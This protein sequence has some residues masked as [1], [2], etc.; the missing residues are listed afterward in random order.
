MKLIVIEI[1]QENLE[2]LPKEDYVVLGEHSAAHSKEA[3]VLY[4]LR[5][6]AIKDASAAYRKSMEEVAMIDIK[7]E[8]LNE[9]EF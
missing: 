2:K 5:G 6:Q 3:S 1:S 4:K 7:L 8:R 9:T